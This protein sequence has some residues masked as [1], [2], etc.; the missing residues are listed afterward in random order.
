ME[1]RGRKIGHKVSKETKLK[2]SKALKGK[3]YRINFK[4]T[5]EAKEKISKA[6]KGKIPWNKEI[7]WS[8]DMKKKISISTRIAMN[9]ANVKKKIKLRPPSYGM[10]NK[11]HSLK[12]IL[13]MSNAQKM[14]TGNKA[15]NW[16]GGKSFEPYDINFNKQLKMKIRKRDNYTCQKC[17]KTQKD[18]GYKLC[19]H[20]IDYNKK[21]CNPDNLI[22]L[23]INCHVKTNFKRY[24]WKNYFKNNF[25]MVQE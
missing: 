1:K 11:K 6:N 25:I 16:Q 7:K 14:F 18:L 21:N 4:H 24:Y 19:V 15:P 22:S 5:K 23:C 10:K 13:K 2:I 3:S 8:D 12:S 17:N 9:N 20:H